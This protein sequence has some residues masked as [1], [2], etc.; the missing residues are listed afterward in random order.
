MFNGLVIDRSREAGRGQL[1][2]SSEWDQAGSVER[3]PTCLQKIHFLDNLVTQIKDLNNA[4]HFLL[5]ISEKNQQDRKS[6]MQRDAHHP[7]EEGD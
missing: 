2:V 3:L 6:C 5:G 7:L 1:D 4:L